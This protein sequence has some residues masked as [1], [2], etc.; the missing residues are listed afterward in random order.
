MI[1]SG[2][3]LNMLNAIFIN[4]HQIRVGIIKPIFQHR[5]NTG[6]LW[7]IT[8]IFDRCPRSSNIRTLQLFTQNQ[9]FH[10]QRNSRNMMK[11]SNGKNF[12]ITDP[13]TGHRSIPLTKAS[14][15]RLNKWSCKQPRRRWFE[16]PSRSLW[17]HCNKW[18][19]VV[20]LP[21]YRCAVES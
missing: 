16:T 8:F 12:R 13:Y 11:S 3:I 19:I 4:Y 9:K 21:K 17:R 2:Y 20:V 1:F 18:A 6:Y 7:N 10:S 5:Q 15:L 14:D